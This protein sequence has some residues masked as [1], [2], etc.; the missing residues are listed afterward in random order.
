[1]KPKEYL[2][3]IGA[4]AEVGRGRLSAENIQKCKD[5]A[6]KGVSIEGYSVSMVSQ[7]NSTAAPEPVVSKVAVS[8][9][10]V[11]REGLITYDIN[12]FIAREKESGKVRSMKEACN[13]CRVSLVGH[14]CSHPTIV[15]TNSRGFVAVEIVSK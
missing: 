2:V 11:I 13:N 6:A 7:P 4:I 3:S 15:A 14:A 9:D 1:M 12:S 5:A 8:T 10:K